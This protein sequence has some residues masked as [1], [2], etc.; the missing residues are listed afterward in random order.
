MATE[1]HLLFRDFSPNKDKQECI[2]TSQ[3]RVEGAEPLQGQ[4]MYLRTRLCACNTDVHFQHA[5]KAALV[6]D[7]ITVWA[8]HQIQESLQ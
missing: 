7:S 3:Q 5:D 1:R 6:A 8:E 2:Q 4:S